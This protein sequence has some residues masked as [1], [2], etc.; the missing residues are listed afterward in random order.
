MH[1]SGD[2]KQSTRRRSKKRVA[3]N[4]EDIKN[5]LGGDTASIVNTKSA[6][7]LQS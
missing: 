1:T 4:K 7:S 2:V 6:M 3:N 5:P